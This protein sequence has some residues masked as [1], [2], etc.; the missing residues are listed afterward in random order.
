MQEK[1]E[2]LKEKTIAA[3]TEQVELVGQCGNATDAQIM[4]ARFHVLNET[5]RTVDN[6]KK[7]WDWETE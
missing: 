2:I 6:I 4:E 3:L 5:L 7:N 1:M